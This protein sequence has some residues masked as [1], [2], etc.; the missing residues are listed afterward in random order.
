MKRRSFIQTTGGALF[1]ANALTASAGESEAAV[2][3]KFHISAAA[4]SWHKMFFNGEIKQIDQPKLAREAG[5]KGL[6]LVNAFFP[7]PQYSY[8][9]ELMKTAE[10]EGIRILLIMCDD[11]GDFSSPDFR[12]Q[13]QAIINHRKW[14]DI[15]AVLGCHSIRVNAG[16][17][18]I[19]PEEDMKTAAASFYELCQYARQYGL[20]VIIEN[21]GQRTEDPKWLAKL[22]ETVGAPNFGTLPDFGNFPPGTD[23]Y[24]AV[25]TL[26]PYA[27]AVSAKCYD[28]DEKG[29][30]TQIDFPRMLDIVLKAGYQGFVGV[31]FEGNRLSEIEGTKA[32]VKLL[33]RIQAGS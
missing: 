17:K 10:S 29:N 28:F 11:E 31:E 12:E 25:E 1:A 32:G 20:N 33:Q 19:S 6:E 9:K 4:W 27:K 2:Q 3:E 22:I 21:H 16:E 30:E 13:R 26:M 24:K 7:S 15:A 14:I 18:H 8:L 23:L 5:A